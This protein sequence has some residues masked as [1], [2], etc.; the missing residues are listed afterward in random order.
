MYDSNLT[1]SQASVNYV[2]PRALFPALL[3][4]I[5]DP[6]DR[7]TFLYNVSKFLQILLDAVHFS[8]R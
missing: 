2:G 7:C 3:G 5:F 1:P 4:F 6:D 8:E